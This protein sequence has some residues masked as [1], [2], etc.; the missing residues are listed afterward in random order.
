MNIEAVTRMK[1]VVPTLEVIERPG[2]THAS[3]VRPSAEP[4][5]AF[6]NKHRSNW[7]GRRNP[8]A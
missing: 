4:L 5:V 1:G 7:G 3:S 8:I 2:A 6:L